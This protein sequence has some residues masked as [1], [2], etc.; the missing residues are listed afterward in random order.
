MPVA[1]L[2][3]LVSA[4]TAP[5]REPT[6]RSPRDIPPVVH[7]KLN[8]TCGRATRR[9]RAFAS[10]RSPDDVSFANSPIPECMQLSTLDRLGGFC[11][12]RV[13]K[14]AD[15]SPTFAFE[16]GSPACET[17]RDCMPLPHSLIG[18]LDL[19]VIDTANG[20][21]ARSD[22]ATTLHAA[23]LSHKDVARAPRCFAGPPPSRAAK[24]QG[25]QSREHPPMPRCRLPSARPDCV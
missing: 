1:E 19:N 8:S 9:H 15:Y 24:C 14:A 10:H 4:V 16:R 12:H 23:A 7:A 6:N 3:G 25:R 18:S 17:A 20:P 22:L 11:N 21:D 2:L 5:H 13:A